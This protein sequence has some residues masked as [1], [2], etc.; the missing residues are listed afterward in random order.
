MVGETN[1]WDTQTG[2]TGDEL[3]R[4]LKKLLIGATVLDIETSSGGSLNR[5]KLK[6]KNGKIAELEE[7]STASWEGSTEGWINVEVLE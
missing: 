1:V 6:L 5:L 4:E 7:E 2:K 3:E